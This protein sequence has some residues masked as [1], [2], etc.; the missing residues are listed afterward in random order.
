[1]YHLSPDQ[2][3]RQE[4]EMENAMEW[5]LSNEYTVTPENVFNRTTH[6]TLEDCQD[7]LETI[8]EV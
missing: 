6:C 2:L 1:M 4:S 7:W 5:L 8:E 3:D